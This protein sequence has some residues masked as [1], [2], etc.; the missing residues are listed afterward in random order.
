MLGVSAVEALR[1]AETVGFAHTHKRPRLT[2]GGQG[3]RRPLPPSGS[4]FDLVPIKGRPAAFDPHP[5]LAAL[6]CGFRSIP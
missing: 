5:V 1:G 4:V 2:L 6:G 3:E